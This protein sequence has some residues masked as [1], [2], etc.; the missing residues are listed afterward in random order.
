MSSPEE[1]RV[2]VTQEQGRNLDG[3]LSKSKSLAWED[4]NAGKKLWDDITC[5]LTIAQAKAAPQ[6]LKLVIER[7]PFQCFAFAEGRGGSWV[8]W[9]TSY[10]AHDYR[11]PG[12]VFL[13]KCDAKWWPRDQAEFERACRFY[14]VKSPEKLCWI[15]F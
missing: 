4:Y 6:R 5:E 1:F 15:P 2:I 10:P 11:Q 9:G 13:F 3:F 12:N 14:G 7:E 8:A